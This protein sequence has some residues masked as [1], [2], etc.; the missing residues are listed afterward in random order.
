MG[1]GDVSTFG[2]AWRKKARRR[3]AAQVGLVGDTQELLALDEVTRRLHMFEQSYL[4]VRP[5]PVTSIVGTVDRSGDFDRDFLPRRPD[6]EGRWERVEEIVERGDMPPIV[7]YEIEGRYFL[8]DGHHRVAI[9]H[10]RGIEYV[11]AEI[12]RMRTRYPFPVGADL[13]QV[14]YSQA[15][16][17]FLDESGLARACPDVRIE[18]SSPSGFA[19]LLEAVKVH[20]YDLCRQLGRFVEP[21]EVARHWHERVY[22]PALSAVREHGLP[23]LFETEL[24]GDLFLALHHR[25][26]LVY[27]EREG[28]SYEDTARM[29]RAEATARRPLREAASKAISELTR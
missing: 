15:K 26:R 23:E 12:T 20:G 18:V 14:I 7:V 17:V 11:D 24:E 3:V 27:F 22:L 28:P 29:T 9:A 19:E 2:R 5:I 21:D 4:G 8:V 6:M 25:M 1:V 10:Q 13:A 16:H